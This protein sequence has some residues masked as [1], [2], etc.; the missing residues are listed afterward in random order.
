MLFTSAKRQEEPLEPLFVCGRVVADGSAKICPKKWWSALRGAQREHLTKGIIVKPDRSE[1]LT[2]QGG[3]VTFCANLMDHHHH[4]HHCSHHVFKNASASIFNASICDESKNEDLSLHWWLKNKS[5]SDRTWDNLHW[6]CSVA[7]HWIQFLGCL[8]M[9]VFHIWLAKVEPWQWLFLGQAV[10]KWG[11][12][13]FAT[14]VRTS[15]V[16]NTSP[17][18]ATCKWQ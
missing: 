8:T 7:S 18:S 2:C 5:N 6:H 10:D 11:G 9:I 12:V 14:T 3:S 4:N 15:T 13:L 17:P 1:G 16:G